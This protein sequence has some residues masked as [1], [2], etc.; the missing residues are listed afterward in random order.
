M[1]LVPIGVVRVRYSDEE[2]KDS[3][4]RG[5]VDGVIEVFPEFEAGLEG[6]D[7]FSHLILIAWLHKVNDE[8]RKVLK[9]RHRRLLRFGIPYEDLPEVG[10]FCTDSPHRPNPIALTIVK[11]VKREGRFLYVE[12]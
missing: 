11:L 8:Q 7:G 2:V 10:V 1:R 6:I 9:V 5:G 12:G 4:I 3:W